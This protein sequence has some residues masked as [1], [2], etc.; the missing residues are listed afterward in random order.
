MQRSENYSSPNI[1]PPIKFTQATI[2]RTPAA[3]PVACCWK[4]ISNQCSG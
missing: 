2:Y 4:C 1:E 3:A